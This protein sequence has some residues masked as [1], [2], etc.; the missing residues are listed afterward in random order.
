MNRYFWSLLCVLAIFIIGC[1]TSDK[2]D[3]PDVPPIPTLSYS[4]ITTHPHDT[5]FFTEGLEFYNN[6]LLEST[7]LYGKSRLVQT[8]LSSG[9]ILKQVKMAPNFFGEG[10]TVLRDTVYQ[11]TYRESQVIVYAAA[12][13]RK[14]KVLP[15][16]GE[17]W[18]LTNDGKFLI[19]SNGSSKL[20]FY[21]PSGF[22]AVKELDVTENGSM[23]LNIN[24]LEYVNGFIY[25][26][27]WQYNTLL[28]IDPA[29]GNVVAKLDLND[30]VKR[31][32]TAESNFLNGIAYN[33]TTKKFYITGKNW[34][35]LYEISFA[36]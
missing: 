4:I 31:T 2:S 9:Q 19:A 6:T 5:S 1:N 14:I 32:N 29:T 24:E 34:P 18:G 13:F 7:G 27:Q 22:K 23:V 36:L 20:Y 8:D 15:L 25:A 12:D 16:T 21:E 10:I 30:I 35:L 28:K 33:P 11:L 3:G 17:G 26:N